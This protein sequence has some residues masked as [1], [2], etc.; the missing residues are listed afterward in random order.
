MIM[1]VWGN[2]IFMAGFHGIYFLITYCIIFYYKQMD[3]SE[4]QKEQ[5]MIL[6]KLGFSEDDLLKGI[7]KKQLF[8]FGIPLILGLVHSY[9]AI[10]SGW[11]IF[12]M[13]MWAP[14]IGRASCRE[15]V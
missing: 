12:G 3:E 5:L 1:L 15:R 4:E 13:E 7:R 2:N 11:F 6:R 9:F 14:K 8:N 10:R